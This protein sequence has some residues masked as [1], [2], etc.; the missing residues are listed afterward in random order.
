MTM[1][2]A[3]ESFEHLNDFMRPG[4][5]EEDDDEEEQKKKKQQQWML[6]S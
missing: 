4:E 2:N 3:S 1:I 5:R 6:L